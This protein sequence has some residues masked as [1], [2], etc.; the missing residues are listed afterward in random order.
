MYCS[1]D[2]LMLSYTLCID[3]DKYMYVQLFRV[4]ALVSVCF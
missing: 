1:F 2:K 3:S 4:G